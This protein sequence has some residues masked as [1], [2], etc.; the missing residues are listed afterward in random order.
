MRT[1]FRG[2][3]ISTVVLALPG[4][5]WSI[6]A[7]SCGDGVLDAGEDCDDGNALDG[8]CCT[9]QCA[10]EPSFH[11]CTLQSESLCWNAVEKFCD[12]AGTCTAGVFSCL[13]PAL[14]GDMVVNDRAGAG[15]DELSWKRMH[16]RDNCTVPPTGDPTTGT[17]YAFCI[18]SL[19]PD[20]YNFDDLLYEQI[21]P[22]G[23]TWRPTSRG[24][25]YATSDSS[26]RIR[27]RAENVPGFK[28]TGASA[29]LPGPV[30]GSEYFGDIAYGLVNSSGWCSVSGFSVRANGPSRY[31]AHSHAVD[32]N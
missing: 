7:A 27:V 11:P 32:C 30:S 23:L 21:I 28:A 3:V 25:R 19:R 2:V 6:A 31:H 12:G 10:F 1:F 16:G 24:W 22:A 17:D 29:A 15:H 14:G 8:D 5:D 9:T 26:G 4:F 18:W 20:D 13:S